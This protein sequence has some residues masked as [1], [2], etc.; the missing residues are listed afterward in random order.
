MVLGLLAAWAIVV[1][2]FLF[3]WARHH[4]AIR[5]ADR[6][7]EDQYVNGLDDRSLREAA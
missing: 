7:D 4:A 1:T 6:I 3:I 2:A 5:A